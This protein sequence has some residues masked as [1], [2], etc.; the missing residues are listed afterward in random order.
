MWLKL[1][2]LKEKLCKNIVTFFSPGIFLVHDDVACII[3]GVNNDWS[4]FP[5]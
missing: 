2:L 1:Y 3:N 4:F 5:H